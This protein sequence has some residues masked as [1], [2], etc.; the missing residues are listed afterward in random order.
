LF[1]H[2]SNTAHFRPQELDPPF[3]IQHAGTVDRL[4]TSSTCMNLLKLP[5]FPDEKIL[6]EKLLYAIQAGAGFELS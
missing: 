1:H 6:R 3:C 2:F 4:P 5:E